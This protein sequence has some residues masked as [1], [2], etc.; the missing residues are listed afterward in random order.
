MVPQF[1]FGLMFGMTTSYNKGYQDSTQ[2]IIHQ[3]QVSENSKDSLHYI[4]GNSTY[5]ASKFY[6]L[7]YKNVNPPRPFV[8]IW[9]S[10]CA[11]KLKVFTWLVLMDTLNVGNIFRRKKRKLQDN[12]YNCVSCSS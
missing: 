10:K 3:T 7:P 6:H 9:D 5:T 1:S 2:Q 8:W 11:N 12:N 4:W